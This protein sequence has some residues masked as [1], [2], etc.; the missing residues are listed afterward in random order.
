MLKNSPLLE[1]QNVNLNFNDIQILH[2]ISFNLFPGEIVVVIGPNG[3]GKTSLAKIIAGILKPNSGQVIFNH[4]LVI[5][6]VP[7]KIKIEKTIPISVARFLKLFSIEQNKNIALK[8]FLEEIQVSNLLSKNLYDLSGGQLQRVMLAGA[9]LKKPQ[10]LILDEPLQGLDI[11]GQAEFYE[12]IEYLNKEEKISIFM[13]SHD[14]QMVMRQANHVICLNQHICCKGGA[15]DI[16]ENPN[17]IKLF[18][19][20]AFSQIGNYTH[21]HDHVH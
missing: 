11:N 5:G 20:K 6:Y 17:F 9:L 1:V 14:L 12:L 21:H 16:M 10:L 3:G 7:Q 13:I 4:N 2:D 8:K 18:G 15:K 19:K